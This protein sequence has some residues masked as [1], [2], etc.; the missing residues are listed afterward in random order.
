MTKIVKGQM[1]I[2]F[3]RHAG[4]LSRWTTGQLWITIEKA[5]VLRV[6]VISRGTGFDSPLWFF[7]FPELSHLFSEIICGSVCL[8]PLCKYLSHMECFGCIQTYRDRI[9]KFW[10][11]YLSVWV[12][13]NKIIKSM[14]CGIVSEM[15]ILIRKVAG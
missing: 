8:F 11:S 14:S 6:D 12:W 1:Q 13:L 3:I 2:I 7:T 9:R 15:M 10:R 4:L 5:V